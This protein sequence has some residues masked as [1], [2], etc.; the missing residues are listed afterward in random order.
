M[1]E[2]NVPLTKED[3]RRMRELNDKEAMICYCPLCLAISSI[4]SIIE[5]WIEPFFPQRL[6]YSI[7]AIIKEQETDD[8]ISN[9]M[10]DPQPIIKDLDECS[11]ERIDV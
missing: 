7:G 6:G 2:L 5:P 10:H 1:S 3:V 11:T 8:D 4:I 9:E